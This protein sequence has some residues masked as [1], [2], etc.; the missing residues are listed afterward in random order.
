MDFWIRFWA[1]VLI[2]SA[3]GFA[4]LAVVVTVGGWRDLRGMLAELRRRSE[5]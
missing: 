4:L 2:A 5:S 1:I 3:S